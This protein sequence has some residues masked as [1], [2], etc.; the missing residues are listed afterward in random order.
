MKLI[1][2]LAAFLIAGTAFAKPPPG[3]DLTSP[4]HAWWECQH[5]PSGMLCCSIADGHVLRDD[6]WRLG[7][8]ADGK[9][10]YQVQIDGKWIDVPPGATIQPAEQCGPEPDP[11]KRMAAKVWYSPALPGFLQPTIYCFMA[12]VLF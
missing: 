10:I 7:K 1:P 2:A 4:E 8:S 6:Q 9:D 11:V 12:G 5:A 3:T